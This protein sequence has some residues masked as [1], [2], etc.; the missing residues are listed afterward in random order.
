[1]VTDIENEFKNIVNDWSN[2]NADTITKGM[3]IKSPGE[4]L[5]FERTLM[6]LLIQLGALIMAWI[7]KTRVQDRNFQKMAAKVVIPSRPKKNS[8]SKDMISL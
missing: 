5:K 4:M 1:M 2:E 8:S 7:I 6:I 3:D